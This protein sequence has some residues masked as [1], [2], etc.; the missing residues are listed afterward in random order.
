MTTIGNRSSVWCAGR[1]VTRQDVEDF[2]YTE[3]DI[4]D[5]WD[6]DGW[7]ALFEP[8]ARFEI[9]TTDYRPGW[10]PHENGSFVDDDWDL[11]L[12]RVKRLKSRKAHAENPHSRTHRLVSNVRLSDGTED[13]FKVA[14]SFVVHRARDGHFDA[15]VGWYDH[16]LVPTEDGLRFR[17]RR[18]VLGHE[19]LAAGARL[20]FIL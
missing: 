20:S 13:S 17:L 19:S 12:A 11:L 7:L 2:L 1:T 16:L 15:Y 5:R 10:S 14:A 6:Y 4:L 9:P 18:S 8:G 3:A